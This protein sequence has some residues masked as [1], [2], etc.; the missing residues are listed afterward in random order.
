M[1]FEYIGPTACG[2]K[3]IV[4]EQLYPESRGSFDHTFDTEEGARGF[5]EDKLKLPLIEAHQQNVIREMLQALRLAEQQMVLED[6]LLPESSG[7]KSVRQIVRSAIEQAE[8]LS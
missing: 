5:V 2:K 1:S 6:V 7:L 4:N 8:K 3:Y